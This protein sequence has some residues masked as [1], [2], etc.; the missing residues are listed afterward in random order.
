MLINVDNDKMNIFTESLNVDNVN[1]GEK[2]SLT[3]GSTPKKSDT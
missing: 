1:P 2:P 3:N